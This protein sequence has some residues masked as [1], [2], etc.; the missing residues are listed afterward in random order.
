MTLSLI[1]GLLTGVLLG[2]RFR[3]FAVLPVQIMAVLVFG[4]G[5]AL[6]GWPWGWAIAA[7]CVWSAALQGGYLVGLIAMP[8]VSA[9]PK[10]LTSNP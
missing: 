8:R 3:A 4:L 1:L 7:F 9:Q 2:G 6:A 10:V 5:I